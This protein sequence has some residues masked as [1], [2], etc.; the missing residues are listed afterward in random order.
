M[1]IN[2]SCIVQRIL[3][4]F[5][6]FFGTDNHADKPFMYCATPYYIFLFLIFGMRTIMRVNPSC[7]VQRILF[8]LF[9]FATDDHA[10][11]PFMYR[12]TC[13]LSISYC[14]YL[15]AIYTRWGIDRIIALSLSDA[16]SRYHLPV[17]TVLVV[18]FLPFL[19]TLLC[20]T[21]RIVV[22]VVSLVRFAWVW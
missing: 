1:R 19:F 17:A 15:S 6:S 12:S 9:L 16:P 21:D 13:D 22:L 2:P 20:A 11:K 7:V 10:D 4:L 14:V 5:F 18:G 8:I 3:F